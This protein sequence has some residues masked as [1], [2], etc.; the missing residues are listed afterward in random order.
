M[1]NRPIINVHCHLLNFKRIPDK[2][3]KLLSHIPENIADDRWFSVAAGALARLLPGSKYDRVKRFLA[4][5]KCSI[6]ELTR[7]YMKEMEQ[8]GIDLCTPLMMDLEPAAPE[9]TDINHPWETQIDLVS[10]EARRY[11]WKI[12]PFVMFDPRRPDAADICIDA[13]ENKGF[14]GVKIYPGLGYYPSEVFYDGKE[15]ESG[16]IKKLY[17]YCGDRKVPI[18]VHASTGGAYSTEHDKDRESGAWPFTEISNW[19]HAIRE[20]NLK[21]NFAHLG[22]NYLNPDDQKRTLSGSW[23]RQIL[24]LIA[25]SRD[26]RGFGEI[27]ADLSFHDMA[28]SRKFRSIYF[29]DLAAL[30]D[31]ERYAGGI[32]FG[33][34]AN[35]ISHTWLEKEYI[36]PF[37]NH[38]S[39]P[40][41]EAIFSANP[42]RFLF[43]DGWIPDSYIRF[44][45]DHDTDGKVFSDLPEWIFQTA[46]GYRVASIL[47][48]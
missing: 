11:P 39:L 31:D 40:H 35:M 45:A 9:S 28:L 27:F 47:R 48:Q 5:L 10:S 20:Y 6:P 17:A 2:M 32:L 34:D 21:I 4:L 1:P 8:A 24:N 30:I 29:R 12:F 38:L 19:I 13:L 15:P 43:P 22:G 46:D 37:K 18:T 16:N 26:E 33:T 41:Q 42:T 23:R 14:I 44:L 25:R 36:A 3:T 7:L